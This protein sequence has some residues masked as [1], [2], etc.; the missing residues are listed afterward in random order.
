MLAT[1]VLLAAWA[2]TRSQHAA[3]DELWAVATVRSYHFDRDRKDYNEDNYGL[4]LEYKGTGRWGA[5]AGFYDNSQSRT[6]VYAGATYGLGQA[7]PAKFGACI[8][9]VTGYKKYAVMPILL[10]SVAFEGKRFGINIGV[11]PKLVG[12]QVKVKF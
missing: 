7:G 3:A 1:C 10:P 9:G 12:L 2:L 5:M 8:C 6:S 4:G 11:L